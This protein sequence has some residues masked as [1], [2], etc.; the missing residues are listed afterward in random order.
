MAQEHIPNNQ[1]LRSLRHE[2]LELMK[3]SLEH[4]LRSTP[5]Q[6]AY[7]VHEMFGGYTGGPSSLAYL[8]FR[9]ADLYPNVQVAGHPLM[10]WTKQYLEGDR[11]EVKITSRAFLSNMPTVLGPY[12]DLKQDPYGSEFWEGRAGTLYFMRLMRH[13]IP[14]SAALLEGPIAQV[15]ERILSDSI[16]QGERGWMF[17]DLETGAG[18]GT[19]GIITQ[20][21]VTTPSLAPRLR[22]KLCAV[23]DLQT[24]GNWPRNVTP[25]SDNNPFLMQWCHGAPGFV[26][27]LKA[28][29]PYFPEIQGRIDAA[30]ANAQEAIWKYGALPHGPRREHFL[31]LATVEAIEEA[32][33]L[34]PGVFNRTDYGQDIAITFKYHS[35]AAWTWAVCGQEDPLM[36]IQ[37]DV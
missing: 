4:V 19:I 25:T 1:P 6:P 2:P 7:E 14:E 32:K 28:I 23:L 35:S 5:P 27:S 3:A 20:L 33:R 16:D 22:T 12:P 30:I 11:G 18:H 31:S 9:L 17:Y 36:L 37:T 21:V 34:E 26:A 13:Y 10:H 24:D 15:S 29:R 8:F